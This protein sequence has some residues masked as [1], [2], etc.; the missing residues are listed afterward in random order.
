MPQLDAISAEQVSAPLR[1]IIESSPLPDL[2]SRQRC[3]RTRR[4]VE[5]YLRDSN[6][7]QLTDNIAGG[8]WLL[9]GELHRSHDYSQQI[10]TPSGSFWHGIMHRREG[11]Y[12]NAKYWFRR[13]GD[14]PVIEQLSAYIGSQIDLSTNPRLKT[15]TDA[16]RFGNTLVDLCE[17]ALPEDVNTLQQ[18]CWWEWQFLFQYDLPVRA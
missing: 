5:E 6:S 8:L 11:D 9:A 4:A 3:A 2:L 14:H 15:L 1:A 18:I 17:Q 16:Q 7:N 13:A 12:G 10:D